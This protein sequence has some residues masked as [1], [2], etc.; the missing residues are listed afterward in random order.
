MLHPYGEKRDGGITGK[1]KNRFDKPAATK[2]EIGG[3]ARTFLA[4]DASE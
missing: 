4:S 3:S 2:A 1:K